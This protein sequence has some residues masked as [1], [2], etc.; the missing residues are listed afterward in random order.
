MKS[1][2]PDYLFLCKI[3]TDEGFLTAKLKAVGC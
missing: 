2:F 1:L 3:E